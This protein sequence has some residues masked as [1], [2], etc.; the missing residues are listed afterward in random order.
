MQL[1]RYDLRKVALCVLF[2][3]SLVVIM[4]MGS[5]AQ[6][7]G[8][9]TE[10]VLA[11][12]ETLIVLQN[13]IQA[14]AEAIE[15]RDNKIALYLNYVQLTGVCA[16]LD[17]DRVIAPVVLFAEAM[18]DCAISYTGETLTIKTDDVDFVARVG[19]DYVEVNGRYLYVEGGVTLREDGHF[20][21]SIENLGRIFGC[22]YTFD[23]DS[24][25][26]YLE[27]TDN[28]IDPTEKYYNDKDLYWLSRIIYAESRGEP[29]V[30]KLAVGTVVMNRVASTNHPNTIYGVIFAPGQFTP[31]ESG[32]VYRAPDEECTI[33]AKIVLDGYRFSEN[34][35]FFHSIVGYHYLFRDFVETETEMVIGNHY[36]YTYYDRR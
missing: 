6:A 26:A 13:E 12:Q 29:F 23:A 19:K 27:L 5:R 16:E 9:T 25:A 20:W 28:Y 11:A 14:E 35:L 22:D 17:G 3:C 2:I 21:M 4:V 24:K 7:D 34:I 30:G 33:A 32:M 10:D 18:C 31:A 15:S 36:F 1:N 8:E